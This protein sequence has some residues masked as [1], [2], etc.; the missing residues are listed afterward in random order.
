MYLSGLQIINFRN[1]RSGCFLFCEGSNTIIGENDSG[2]SNAITALRMLLD[3]SFFYNAK[4]LKESDFSYTLNDWRGHWIIISASFSGI[5]DIDKQSEICANLMIDDEE[6]SSF[7]S[8]LLSNDSRDHGVVTLFIRPQKSIRKKLFDAS[9]DP[10][11]FGDVRKSIKLSD[12]EFYFTSK[13]KTEFRNQD[14]YKQIVGDIDS[15]I[16]SNPEEDDAGIIGTSVS[17]SDVRNHI[18][19]VFVDALRDVLREMHTPR[20]PV[21][22]IIEA[23][24]GNISEAQISAVQTK[25]KDLNGAITDIP[26]IGIIGKGMNKKLLD[27]LGVVYSPEISMSSE[28]SDELQ[29][30]SKFIAIKPSNEDDL[31]L[32]GLGHLNMIYIALKIIEFEACRSR[33]LLNIMVIEEP[34]A[35]IHSHIQKT[36][37]RNLSVEKNYTQILMTTHSSHLAE[38]SEISRMNILKTHERVSVAMQPVCNLDNFGTEKLKRKTLSLTRAIERYLDAK[39]TTLLFSKGVLLVE[40]DGEEILIPSMLLS[41]YGVSLDELGIGLVNV[42]STAFEY[43]AS[44]FHDSRIRRFC[45]IITDLDKQSVDESSDFYKAD[46]ESKG[47]ERKKKLEELYSDNSWVNIFYAE[48]TFE[49]E[50]A[51]SSN[52]YEYVEKCIDKVFVQGAAILRHQEKVKDENTRNDEILSLAKTAGKGWLSTLVAAEIDE[53]VDIPEYIVNALVFASKETMSVQIYTKMIRHTLSMYEDKESIQHSKNLK[54][55]KSQSE[56]FKCIN[57]IIENGIYAKD[58]VVKFIKLC[59]LN[60][61]FLGGA[62]E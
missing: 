13:S 52:N 47:L 41:A 54:N 12:Y 11:V 27:I 38:S 30:L 6:N 49:I 36:L 16:A 28:L 9:G 60:F 33:E 45:A 7:T 55:A 18:S 62:D 15:L 24:E 61:N 43:I 10:L 53:L 29:S 20:N 19:L 1:F 44:I 58:S 26:E 35:H 32:L 14:I 40:G 2:K 22:R 59:E 46:A 56:L 23:I 50:F 42:G 17:I 25:I 31:D 8:L 4:R 51:N 21:R 34:E 37:F 39:R 5:T 48:H 3:D 57:E